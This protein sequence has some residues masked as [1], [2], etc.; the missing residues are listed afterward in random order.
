M[1]E[2]IAAFCYY[3]IIGGQEAG[4]QMRKITNERDALVWRA[5]LLSDWIEPKG[6]KNEAQYPKNAIADHRIRRVCS[7]SNTNSL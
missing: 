5:C 3:A 4:R 1:V 2:I 6:A 7:N